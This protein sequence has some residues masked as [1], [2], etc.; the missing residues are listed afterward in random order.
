MSLEKARAALEAAGYEDR[1]RILPTST[2]T[3]ALAAEALGCDEDMIA[4]TLSFQEGERVLIIVMSGLSRVDNRKFRETFHFKAH[5]IPFEEAEAKTGHAPGGVCPFGLN[6]GCE[7][8]LDVSLKKHE[9]VYPAAG[10][11]E[12][13]V[14]LTVAELEE[15]LPQALWIDVSKENQ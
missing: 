12:S 1:I 13:A 8:Y 2:A 15:I 3:V 4:K 9:I 10:S 11:S 5:M 7:V 6:E 14:K